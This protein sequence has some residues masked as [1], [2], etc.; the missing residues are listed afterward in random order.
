MSLPAKKAIEIDE[1][2]THYIYKMLSHESILK[3]DETKCVECGFCPLYDSVILSGLPE[4]YHSSV[5]NY[6]A[7]LLI[8]QHRQYFSVLSFTAAMG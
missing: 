8:I 1:N 2:I 4:L 6:E 3:Y 7:Y 5:G